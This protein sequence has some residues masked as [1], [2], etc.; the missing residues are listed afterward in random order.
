MNALAYHVKPLRDVLRQDPIPII[1]DGAV[2]RKHARRELLTE[3]DIMEKLRERGIDSLD[4]VRR[5]YVEPDGRISVVPIRDDL[6]PGSR[7]SP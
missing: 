2:V 1:E 5:A 6:T 4:A 3:A 7:T